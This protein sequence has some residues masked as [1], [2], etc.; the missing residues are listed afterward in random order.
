MTVKKLPILLCLLAFIAVNAR[1]QSRGSGFHGVGPRLGFTL[2]PDQFHLGGQLDLGD[3]TP[4]LMMV[5][6]L[7]IG[8]GDHITTVAPSFELD[9]RFRTNWSA[10]TPYLG[11]GT[12][13]IFY[14]YAYGDSQTDLGVYIQ[15]GLSRRMLSNTGFF[16]VEFKLGLVDAPDAKFTVGWTFGK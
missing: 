6:N 14:S 13:P 4:G 12:G 10:W 1:A 2:N 9:Y 7:E 11:G 15:G 5:P 3:I 16:F 8:V